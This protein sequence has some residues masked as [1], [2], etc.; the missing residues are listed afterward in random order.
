MLG[1]A[2]DI[3][4]TGTEERVVR[5]SKHLLCCFIAW[6]N[7]R[8]LQFQFATLHYSVKVSQEWANSRRGS[9]EHISSY[10]PDSYWNVGFCAYLCEKTPFFDFFLR[11][12]LQRK[13]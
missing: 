1:K 5:P 2:P 12:F 8:V 4:Y 7:S 13:G 3:F 10:S 6:P 11:N 9:T